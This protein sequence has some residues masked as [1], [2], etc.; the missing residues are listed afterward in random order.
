M[1]SLCWNFV[2]ILSYHV[3]PTIYVHKSKKKTVRKT[4]TLS[5][6]HDYRVKIFEMAFESYPQLIIG[7]FIWQGL[8]IKEI[9]NFVSISMS[10]ASTVY[11]MGDLLAFHVFYDGYN[12]RAPFYLTVYGMLATG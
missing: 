11:G 6:F 3:H 9:L 7:L 12:C 10:V 5:P 4:L 8:Q 2:V 1:P